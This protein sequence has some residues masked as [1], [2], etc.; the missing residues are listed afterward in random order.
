[1][2]ALRSCTLTLTADE[3]HLVAFC[4]RPEDGGST[5]VH[6]LSPQDP[7]LSLSST[8]EVPAGE[9]TW[10]PQKAVPLSVSGKSFLLVLKDEM[11]VDLYTFP[12]LKRKGSYPFPSQIQDWTAGRGNLFALTRCATTEVEDSESA[13]LG[14]CMIKSLKS[15]RLCGVLRNVGDPLRVRLSRDDTVL[16]IVGSEET[17]LYQSS[18]TISS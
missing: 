2:I 16:I 11:A 3:A 18:E 6:L 14:E 4:Q 7:P 13:L 12:A 1:L 10:V 9:L 8:T 15:N 17:V 5:A